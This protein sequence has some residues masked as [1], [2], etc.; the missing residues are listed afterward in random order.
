MIEL[1]VAFVT[2]TSK[3]YNCIDL[4]MP[5]RMVYS[6]CLLCEKN[7]LFIDSGR[8]KNFI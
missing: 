3:P 1:A 6:L 8:K 5:K 7:R 4:F 2:E